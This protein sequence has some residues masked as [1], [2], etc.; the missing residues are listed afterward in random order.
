VPSYPPSGDDLSM[1]KCVRCGQPIKEAKTYGKGRRSRGHPDLYDG[2][3]L[4]RIV[5][6]VDPA[7]PLVDLVAFIQ[8]SITREYAGVRSPVAEP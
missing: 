2:T 6:D 4:R 8:S 3:P 5:C 7:R 1:A